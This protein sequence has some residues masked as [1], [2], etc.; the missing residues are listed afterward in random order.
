MDKKTFEELVFKNG[1]QLGDSPYD[2]TKL[3]IA[4]GTNAAPD[5]LFSSATYNK[6]KNHWIGG[7]CTDPQ[8]GMIQSIVAGSKLQHYAGAAWEEV[9][10]ATRSS[11]VS[12]VFDH[13]ALGGA[14]I[15]VDIGINFDEVMTDVDN[16]IKYGIY[17]YLQVAKVAAVMTSYAIGLNANCVL[18][19]TNTQNWTNAIGLYGVQGAIRT[20][21]GSAGT[22]TGAACF[23]AYANVVDAATVTNLYGLYIWNPTV[24]GNKV[25]NEYGIYIADQ[26]TGLTLNYAIYTN[27]GMVRFGDIVFINETANTGMTTG[28]TINQGDTDDEILALKSSDVAH[29][30]TTITETDTYGLFQKNDAAEGGVLFHGL[31]DEN[32]TGIYAIA[33]AAFHESGNKTVNSVG[34]FMVESR[35]ISGTGYTN[36][37]ANDNVFVWRC[38]Y[39]GTI[40]TIAVLTA[41]GDFHSTT[42]LLAAFPD[43]YDDIALVDDLKRYMSTPKDLKSSFKDFVKYN[44]EKLVEIGV[45]S[46]GDFISMKGMNALLLGAI[47]QLGQ[48]TRELEKK[49]SLLES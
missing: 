26:N 18:D 35:Y 37:D 19:S 41:D 16:S 47:S 33:H 42:G 4:T 22:V 7:T 32:K 38:S 49:L 8:N 31:A 2:P 36:F 46:D 14:A 10:Q 3:T 25:T 45:I 23:A 6:I 20:E 28:L 15:D 40:E 12:P 43:K 29:G 11:D 44:R 21:V 9:L 1:I 30:V 48:K 24:A 5:D 17:S 34:T 39:G 27:A 13:L